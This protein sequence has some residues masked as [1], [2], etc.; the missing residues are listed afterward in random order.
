MTHDWVI[1]DYE[2]AQLQIPFRNTSVLNPLVVGRA[3]TG[4]VSEKI[5]NAFFAGGIPIY[6][7]SLEVFDIFNKRAFVYFDIGNPRCA[8]RVRLIRRYRKYC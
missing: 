7:G 8:F 5:L 2:L 4:Y 3:V 6:Y 1:V